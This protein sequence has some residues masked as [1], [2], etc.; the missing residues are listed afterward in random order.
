MS[1][2][3]HATYQ[4]TADPAVA[5][6]LAL[7]NLRRALTIALIGLATLG[8]YRWDGP[9]MV[10]KLLEANAWDCFPNLLPT[11]PTPTA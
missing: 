8:L 1:A 3:L 4:R 5:E 10:D 9:V 6:Q 11:A 2:E 7:A